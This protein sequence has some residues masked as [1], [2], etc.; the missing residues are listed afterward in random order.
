MS[1]APDSD[2]V[3]VTADLRHMYKQLE[4]QPDD[5]TLCGVLADAL[6]EVGYSTLPY[7]YRWMAARRV[8]P[9]RRLNYG[10]S[11]RPGRKV[12][13]KFRW[14]WYNKYGA[15]HATPNN[16]SKI[17]EIAPMVPAA[18][19]TLDELLLGRPRELFKSHTDAVRFL[20][21]RL[22]ALMSVT[23]LEVKPKGIL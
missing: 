22:H 7:A 11:G 12:P 19:H 5:F 14:A 17:L 16:P 10:F 3:L 6:E 8:Y 18:P 21:G 15:S 9:H 20:A 23:A 1:D 2:P 4:A 13:E